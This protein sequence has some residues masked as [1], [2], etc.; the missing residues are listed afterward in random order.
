[1]KINGVGFLAL[2]GLLFVL[3]AALGQ[4]WAGGVDV[5]QQAIADSLKD[6][7]L[8]LVTDEAL[9]LA[10]LS[11]VGIAAGIAFMGIWRLFDPKPSNELAWGAW[12]LRLKRVATLAGVAWA[13]ALNMIFLEEAYGLIAKVVVAS[14]PS[15]IAGFLTPPVYDYMRRWYRRRFPKRR[16]GDSDGPDDDVTQLS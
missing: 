9:M 6:R 7:A 5:Q 12:A 11:A 8:H 2:V 1:M 3:A 13:F 4:A 10:M 15:M 14:A 16:G